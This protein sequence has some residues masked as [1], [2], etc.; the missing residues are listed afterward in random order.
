VS[1]EFDTGLTLPQR[2]IIRRAAL[3]ILS[4]LKRVNGGYL[5]NVKAFGGV[6]R[7]YTDE[8][9]IELLQKA[10]GSTPAIGIALAT[11]QFRNAAVQSG[12]KLGDPRSRAQPQALSELQMRLYFANQHG[13]DGLTGRHELDS[14]AVV[15]D[16]ADPGLD[17]MMEHALELMHGSYPTA[18]V[19]TIK[20]IEIE[21]EEE[22]ATLPEVTI[23]MQTYK[24]TLHSYTGSKEFRTA[25]QLIDSLH[26]RVTTDLNEPNRPDPAVAPSTVDVDSDPP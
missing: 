8:P 25:E 15:D 4:P 21:T 18:T 16:L 14:V 24:I 11:R 19:G 2:T 1:H 10:L 9:D 3:Q 5:A 7:T 12:R 22:L 17:V 13:R 20:Q 26:W 6:V 23:W